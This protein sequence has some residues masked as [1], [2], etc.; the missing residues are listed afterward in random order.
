MSKNI[1]YFLLFSVLMLSAGCQTAN[2]SACGPM[3]TV[4]QV[5]AWMQENLW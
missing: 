1:Q 2:G 3:C 4:N 5:D